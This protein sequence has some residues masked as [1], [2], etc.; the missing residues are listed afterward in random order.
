M[1]PESLKFLYFSLS[2]L[3]TFFVCKRK[4]RPKKKKLIKKKA[5][6]YGRK[7]YKRKTGCGFGEEG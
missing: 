6:E 4:R 5:A 2:L 1:D 7:F 3:F